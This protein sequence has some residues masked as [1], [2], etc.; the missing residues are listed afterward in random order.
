MLIDALTTTCATLLTVLTMTSSATQDPEAAVSVPVTI[1][2]SVV[3]ESVTSDDV[4]TD[5]KANDDSAVDAATPDKQ[6]SASIQIQVQT[7][8]TSEADDASGSSK[9]VAGKVIVIGPDGTKREFDLNQQLPEEVRGI[10]NGRFTI[11]QGD[12]VQGDAS[13]SPAIL[14]W[15][16]DKSGADS[17]KTGRN[18]TMI[19]QRSEIQTAPTSE[20]KVPEKRLMIGVHCGEADQLLRAHLKLEDVG[21]VVVDVVPDSPA[22][23][24]GLLKHDLLLRSGDAELKTVH[25]LLK[26][27]EDSG[28]EPVTLRLLRNG[29]PQELTVTPRIMEQPSEVVVTVWGNQSIPDPSGGVAAGELPQLQEYLQQQQLKQHKAQLR[30]RQIPPG[31]MIEK[32]LPHEEI[33]R[34]V[35]QAMKAARDSSRTQASKVESVPGSQTTE[36]DTQSEI[37]V[38]K[39]QLSAVMERLKQL[40]QQK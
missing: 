27:V 39:D 26:S 2:E 33:E 28:E 21:L 5:Q 31:I 40:E 23:E 3:S 37:K 12:I 32:S 11:V 17:G 6:T 34:L 16:T 36:A 22:A 8:V 9:S 25:D 20:P 15:Q 10:V 1:T 13:R 4:A 19:L 24:A 38:L 7:Q 18:R 14:R 35:E 29:D 30:L